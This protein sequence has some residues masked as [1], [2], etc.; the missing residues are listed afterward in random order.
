MN[1]FSKINRQPS[2]YLNKSTMVRQFIDTNFDN[3][4]NNN[5]NNFNQ[6][7]NDSRRRFSR[8]SDPNAASADDDDP[9][10]AISGRPSCDDEEAKED[11]FFP[12]LGL[13]HRLEKVFG[14]DGSRWGIFLVGCVPASFVL[15]GI[16]G[17]VRFLG[18]HMAW[19]IH[20]DDLPIKMLST[21]QNLFY[22][23]QYLIVSHNN[24]ILPRSALHGRWSSASSQLSSFSAFFSYAFSLIHL[25]F[26]VFLEKCIVSARNLIENTCLCHFCTQ[27]LSKT[28]TVESRPAG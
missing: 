25:N 11:S 17:D 18:F 10:Q 27:N 9:L 16:L 7:P 13:Q 21:V 15:R 3:L 8:K 5:I 23:V 28:K 24:R 20:T 14:D 22:F 12:N 1:L 2:K 26:E 4:R 19:C 6:M